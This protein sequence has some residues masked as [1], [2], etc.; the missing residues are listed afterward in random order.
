MFLEDEE[1]NLQMKNVQL[2]TVGTEEQ[3]LHYHMMGSF[4]RRTAATCLNQASSRSHCIFTLNIR[5][6]NLATLTEVY[7]KLH[8]VD[9]AGSERVSRSQAEGA[10]LTEARSINLSLTYL[11]QVIVSLN[12]K[13]RGKAKAAHVPYRNSLLTTLLRDSLG[14]NCKTVMIATIS[15]DRANLDET[16]STLRFA[17]RVKL[18]QNETTKNEKNP[19]STRI[20]LLERENAQLRKR[21]AQFEGEG[22]QEDTEE[23]A[24]AILKFMNQPNADLEV[25]SLAQARRYFR[26]MKELYSSRMSEYVKELTF[27]SEKLNRYDAILTEKHRKRN[28]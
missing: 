23:D 17:Q 13:A 25:D 2:R 28:S 24:A 8:L 22:E 12:Q 7:S 16:I 3:A 15:T 20:D 21:L 5:G 1:A 6:K 4:V 14:G 18:V 27:I 9:L 19:Y 26:K 10:V 11:E